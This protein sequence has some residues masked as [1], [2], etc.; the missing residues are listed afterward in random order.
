MRPE[1]GNG[2][3]CTATPKKDKGILPT[4]YANH[5]KPKWMSI[6]AH[7]YGFLQYAMRLASQAIPRLRFDPFQAIDH[8]SGLSEVTICNY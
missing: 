8:T 6:R 1:K 4:D 5:H 3:A 7:H 2:L